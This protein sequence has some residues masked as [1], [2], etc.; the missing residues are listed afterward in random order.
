MNIDGL[1]NFFEMDFDTVV[2]NCTSYSVEESRGIVDAKNTTN[3]ATC[4]VQ[5]YMHD[6]LRPRLE[7]TRQWFKCCTYVQSECPKNEDLPPEDDSMRENKLTCKCSS[8]EKELLA[9]KRNE[10]QAKRDFNEWDK[11]MSDGTRSPTMKPTARPTKPTETSYWPTYLPTLERDY[12]TFPPTTLSPSYA[13]T[14]TEGGS[15]SPIAGTS[16]PSKYPSNST[17]SPSRS[18]SKSPVGGSPS[19]TRSPSKSPSD[20]PFESLLN[21]NDN[22]LDHE[23]IMSPMQMHS[24]KQ[25]GFSNL[26]L[27]EGIKSQSSETS[28]PSPYPGIFT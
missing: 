5:R 3:V 1:P 10:A 12:E 15:P 6:R 16:S 23:P 19:P 27:D 28:I 21:D 9:Q 24:I 7:I 14:A 8:A 25:P 20:S 13:P 22:A 26:S 2:N 18:P 11:T 17:S 4:A